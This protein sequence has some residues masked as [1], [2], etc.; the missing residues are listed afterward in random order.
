MH[1]DQAKPLVIAC[2]ASQYG[3]GAVLSH[4]I[5]DKQERPVAYVSRTLSPAE[6]RYSELEKED[7]AIVFAV[8]KFHKYV[9]GR[10]F[11]IESDHCPLSFLFSENKGVP[12]MASAR[13]QRWAITLS[14][15]HYTIR[16]KAGKHLSNADA[17]SRLLRPVTIANDHVPEE[18]ELLMNHLSATSIGSEHQSLD[19]P[20]PSSVMCS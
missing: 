18:L 2:E 16:Y 14:A 13:I 6:K 9:Y 4:N 11:E 12:Q 8:K 17:F 15:Y 19:K 20:R 5:E 1:Y 10:H 7:L 3:I